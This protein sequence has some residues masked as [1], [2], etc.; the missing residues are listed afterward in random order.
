MGDFA[1]H[2]SQA[3][4]NESLAEFL[5]DK[6][7]FDW[8]ITAC[9]YSAIHYVEARL[10]IEFV[11]SD[12]KHSETSIP[13]DDKGEWL[14]TPHRWR[15][16]LIQNHFSKS[17]WKS[18]RNIKEASELA[19]YLSYFP[20]KQASFKDVPS[21]KL[22][23]FENA[24]FSLDIDLENIKRDLRIELCEFLYSLEMEKTDPI[25]AN[26][27]INKILSNFSTKEE[28]LQLGKTSFKKQQYLNKEELIFLK[29]HLENKGLSLSSDT[30]KT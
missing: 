19:R 6:P 1:V 13:V 28:V 2:V 18:F 15:E 24:Q 20:N 5:L 12:K 14:V 8:S 10:F 27:I 25:R 3:K 23:E 21:F 16:R 17:V 29:Q 11:E 22:F 30:D 26:L 7:Y 4:H 9:F